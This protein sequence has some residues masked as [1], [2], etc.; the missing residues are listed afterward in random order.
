MCLFYICMRFMILP[1]KKYPFIDTIK[2]YKKTHLAKVQIIH[3][4]L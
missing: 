1:F 4:N 3:V 2:C